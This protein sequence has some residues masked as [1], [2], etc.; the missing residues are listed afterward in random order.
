M[1]KYAKIR[2]AHCVRC[3]SKKAI[4]IPGS[5]ADDNASCAFLQ[6]WPPVK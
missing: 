2:Q 5:S 1:I 6:D 4:R 3:N